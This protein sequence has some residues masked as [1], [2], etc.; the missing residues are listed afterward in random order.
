MNVIQIPRCVT[1]EPDTK[2]LVYAFGGASSSAYAAVVYLVI[3][4]RISIQVC[5]IASKTRVAPLK[6]ST[7]RCLKKTLGKACLTYEELL[8]VLTEVECVLNSRP[9]SYLYPDD[10]EEPLTPSHL[11]SGRR[12]LSLPDT[13]RSGAD[14]SSTRETV[15]R[16]ARYLHRLMD[17]LWNRW[18]REYI[19]ALRE[20]HRLKLDSPG[21][22]VK[23]GDIVSV[24]D[25]SLP[26]TKWRMGV[27]HELING[28]DKKARGA[29]VR[30]ADKGKSSYLR[31]PLQRLFPLEILD[32]VEKE[33][34]SVSEDV[35]SVNEGKPEPVQ[36]EPKEMLSRPRRQAARAGEERRRLLTKTAS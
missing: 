16:R 34:E 27:V 18:R 35:T 26:H 23:I 19:P 15:T 6:K 1:S 31:R 29:V 21:Q 2:E 20:S 36:E 10:L 24:H 28:V 4:S 12:L 7:K 25:E 30:I 17:H 11:S 8:T 9:L 22:T 13:T 14:S 3:K 33:S 5:L 32:D